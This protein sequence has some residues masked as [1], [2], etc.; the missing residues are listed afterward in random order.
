LTEFDLGNFANTVETLKAAQN[1]GVLDSKCANLL[2]VAYSKLGSYEQAY[3]VLADNLE[4]YPSDLPSYLNIVTVFS[5]AGRFG[6]AADVATQAVTAFP[7]NADVLVARG[8]IYTQLGQLDKAK[9]DFEA[10]IELS[11]RQPTPRLLLALS[12]YKLNDFAGASASL[13]A[14][15]RLGAVDSDVYYLHSECLLKVDPANSH[16]AIVELD[17]AIALDGKSVKARTLRGKLLLDSG[18]FKAAFND[19]SL[20]HQLDP[21]LRSAAYNL[22]RAESKL[23]MTEEAKTLFQQLGTANGEAPE[24]PD[25]TNPKNAP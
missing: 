21:G 18:Q 19:L 8:S 12:Q 20:A 22:A 1:E 3:T 10:A 2:G 23:G 5:D 17:H 7:G 11:P 16:E 14:A 6:Q 24:V 13:Q 4:R 15:I 9:S 25:G